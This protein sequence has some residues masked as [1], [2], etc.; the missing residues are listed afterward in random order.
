MNDQVILIPPGKCL[1]Q[2]TRPANSTG[3]GF[4]YVKIP[5][6]DNQEAHPKRFVTLMKGKAI[7]PLNLI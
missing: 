7:R 4:T 6:K 3:L 2:L 1:L 5:N